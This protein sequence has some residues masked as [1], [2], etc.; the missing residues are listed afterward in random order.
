M[1]HG[2][3]WIPT[4]QIQKH[5]LDLFELVKSAVE[6]GNKKGAG[7]SGAY[8][9]TSETNTIW[10]PGWLRTRVCLRS[11]AHLGRLGR[12]RWLRLRNVRATSEPWRLR[13]LLRR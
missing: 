7:V 9:L 13:L 2:L 5:F 1:H 4:D 3:S 6:S 12:E 11:F 10:D 8:H